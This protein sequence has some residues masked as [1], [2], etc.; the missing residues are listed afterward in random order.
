MFEQ[1]LGGRGIVGLREIVRDVHGEP[2]DLMTVLG[3]PVFQ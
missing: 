2:D 3:H 1:R